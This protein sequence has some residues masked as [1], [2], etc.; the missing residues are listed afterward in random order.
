M[1]VCT[2]IACLYLE[3]VCSCPQLDEWRKVGSLQDMHSMPKKMLQMD[4][5]KK[6]QFNKLMDEGAL[7]EECVEAYNNLKS[8]K[9]QAVVINS[10]IQRVGPVGN[11]TY[12]VNTKHPILK[13]R[14][15]SNTPKQENI[16]YT[17]NT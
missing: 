4:R 3:S 6:N 10:V 7:E 15:T 11:C 9:Q 17:W 1:S 8:K 14:K 16:Q 13:D 12:K 5:L 2:C